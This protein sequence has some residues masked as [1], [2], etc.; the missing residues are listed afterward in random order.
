MLLAP[1]HV[2]GLPHPKIHVRVSRIAEVIPWACLARIGVSETLVNRLDIATAPAEELWCAST[3][4]AGWGSNTGRAS[5]D[6]VYGSYVGLDVPVG[7]P[8]SVVERRSNR[9]SGV[10]TEDAGE[11]RSERGS[12]NSQ[13]CST[14]PAHGIAVA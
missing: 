13:S 8:A 12:W 6:R 1:R 2:E 7:C 4:G 5:V 11:K 9:Q 3:A 10:P 14:R